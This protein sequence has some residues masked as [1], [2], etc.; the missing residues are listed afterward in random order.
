[1]S[2]KLKT[3]DQVFKIE[4]HNNFRK[5]YVSKLKKLK[6]IDKLSHF[7]LEELSYL[8]DLFSDTYCAS[9]LSVDEETN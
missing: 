6:M 7:T 1:M 3:V 9:F 4:L 2:R 5:S 8:W